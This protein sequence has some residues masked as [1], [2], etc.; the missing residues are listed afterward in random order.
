MEALKVLIA[1]TENWQQHLRCILDIV[2]TVTSPDI[3]T[4]VF[5]LDLLAYFGRN[6]LHSTYQVGRSFTTFMPCY[7]IHSRRFGSPVLPTQ[8]NKVMVGSIV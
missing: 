7:D 3:V 8:S 2:R 1:R 6:S 5:L 4:F